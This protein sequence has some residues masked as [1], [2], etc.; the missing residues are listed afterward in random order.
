MIG[1]IY[2]TF[3][4][5]PFTSSCKLYWNSPFFVQAKLE[6]EVGLTFDEFDIDKNGFISCE[7]VEASLGRF[8]KEM[9]PEQLKECVAVR[10]RIDTL[11][12]NSFETHLT[13]NLCHKCDLSILIILQL[14]SHHLSYN[15]ISQLIHHLGRN[16][17]HIQMG[18]K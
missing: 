10:S 14:L 6:A 8:E 5:V 2:L 17:P 12:Q 13:E 18:W 16:G 15:S 9:T 11:K 1:N 3:I 4:I 7:E